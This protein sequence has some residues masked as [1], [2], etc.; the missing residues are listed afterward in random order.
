MASY[1]FSKN[2]GL[3][4]ERVGFC[5]FRG[6]KKATVD[7]VKVAAKLVARTMWNR[8]VKY[9]SLLAK[10]VLLNEKHRAEWLKNVKGVCDRIIAMRKALV[11]NLAKLG[12][13]HD[14]SHIT[15]QAGMFAYTGLSKE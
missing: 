12:S 5:A 15:K 4:G 1:S 11:E 8:P 6:Y 3:Y 13:K 7:R 10:K 2:M 9:G 14:W